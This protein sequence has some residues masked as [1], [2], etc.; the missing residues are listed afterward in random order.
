[1]KRA[2]VALVIVAVLALAWAGLTSWRSPPLLDAPAGLDALQAPRIPA[3]ASDVATYAY[4]LGGSA[5]AV[6]MFGA[7]HTRDPDDPAIAGIARAWDEFGPTVALVEGRLGFL[8]PPFMDPVATYGEGG[9]VVRL[10]RRAGIPV[11]SWEPTRAAE[12]ATVVAAVGRERAAAFF[13]TRPMLSSARF[14]AP[15]DY[16]AE[17]RA[18]IAERGQWP[19]L[20]GVIATV[21]DLDRT[22]RDAVGPEGPDWRG[23]SDEYGWPGPFA[24]AALAAG[25]ARDDHLLRL[26]VERV[27]RGERVFVIA[28]TGHALLLEDALREAIEAAAR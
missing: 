23:A 26:A 8:L 16:E 10:A 4:T 14:G 1:M 17:A 3:P 2:L 15:A 5:G 24:A 7:R 25:G 20:D 6:L 28:G 27:N 18:L 9:E 11:F 22:W 21:A 13:I 19:G 12:V